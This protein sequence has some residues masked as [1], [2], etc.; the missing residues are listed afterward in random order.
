M[1]DDL[2][3]DKE[4][5]DTLGKEDPLW[6][7]LTDPSKRGHKWNID[8][9]FQTGKQEIES[10]MNE[11]DNLSLKTPLIRGKALDFGCGVG[12]LTRALATYFNEVTGLDISPSMIDNA[13][14]FNTVGERLN[15][16]VNDRADLAP[17]PSDS[18]DL[19]YSSITLQHI[20]KE[21]IG[22]YIAEFIRVVTRN[23][24]V[25]F[26]LPAGY[27]LTLKGLFLRLLPSKISNL[28]RKKKYRCS[29][30][31][32]MNCIPFK[33]VVKKVGS[34]GGEVIRAAKDPGGGQGWVSYR[35]FVQK[36][37]A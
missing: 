33:E 1:E 36:K 25:V 16:C 12:R 27:N 14:K 4:R 21:F 5:W 35:Y 17:I 24:L 8:D 30:A 28:I 22:D 11:I 26:Q 2:A 18:I 37:S 7:I 3:R 32:E 10:L 29:V 34:N 31:F 19:L 6:V 13:R 20:R 15:Y 23:G 9:F